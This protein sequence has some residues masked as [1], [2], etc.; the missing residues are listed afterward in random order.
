MA[1]TTERARYEAALASAHRALYR[2][3]EQA[4]LMGDDGAAYDAEQLLKETLRLATDSLSGKP[5]RSANPDQ[6][7][8]D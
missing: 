8:L 3:A 7:R 6:L 4:E 5:R 2:A 1:Y